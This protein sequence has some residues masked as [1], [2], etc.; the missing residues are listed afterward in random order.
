MT[1]KEIVLI[2]RPK[3]CC[4]GKIGQLRA[5]RKKN[6]IPSMDSFVEDAQVG[7]YWIAFWYLD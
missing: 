2:A 5:R 7:K 6:M 4:T 3:L 1:C